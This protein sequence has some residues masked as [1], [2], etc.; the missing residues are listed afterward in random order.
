MLARGVR[1]PEPAPF[2]SPMLIAAECGVELHAVTDALAQLEL[3]P[4]ARRQLGTQDG[5]P[6]YVYGPE[7]VTAVR[8]RLR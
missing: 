5:Q 4:E 3:R 2:I 1:V 7:V 8:E 6:F